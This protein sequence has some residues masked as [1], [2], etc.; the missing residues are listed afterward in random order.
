MVQSVASDD[1]G[2]ETI[3]VVTR[4]GEVRSFALPDVLAAKV[5]P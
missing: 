5:F 1:E 3:E 4:R 2:R